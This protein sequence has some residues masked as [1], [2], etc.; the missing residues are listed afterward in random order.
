MKIW[1]KKSKEEKKNG[2]L[3]YLFLL[4]LDDWNISLEI[5]RIK[6]ARNQAKE[7]SIKIKNR[8]GKERGKEKN[9][10]R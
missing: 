2:T 10:K 8:K 1:K 5:K 4:Y 3:V 9:E 7:Q 6:K